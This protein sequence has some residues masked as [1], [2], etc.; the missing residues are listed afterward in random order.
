MKILKGKDGRVDI[1]AML[2]NFC[3]KEHETIDYQNRVFREI[4]SVIHPH[5][6]EKLLGLLENADPL[7]DG[8][9]EP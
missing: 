7:N 3:G 4:Y 8:R 6:E 5:N 1:I 2:R 9:V